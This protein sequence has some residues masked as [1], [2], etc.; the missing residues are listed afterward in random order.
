MAA[1]RPNPKHANRHEWNSYENYKRVNDQKLE[2]Y[3][4]IEGIELAFVEIDYEGD[5][6]IRMDAT[7][8]L[9]KDVVLEVTKFF[10]TERRGPGRGRLWV[11]CISYRY[12]ARIR[13]RHNI[14]RYDNGHDL[15]D[16]HGHWFNIASGEEIERR[17][18]SRNDF[19]L[20]SEV[21]DELDQ[22]M[23]FTGQT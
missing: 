18:M 8:W 9:P 20:F 3:P 6:F 19:P 2:S 7:L 14:L 15:D 10:E 12:N 11:R 4:F 5:L 13:N 23:N 16:Y 22:I 1:R 17:S 21:L